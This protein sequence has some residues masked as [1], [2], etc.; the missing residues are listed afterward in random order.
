MKKALSFAMAIGF[1]L[2]AAMVALAAD[3]PP[4]P[5]AAGAAQASAKAGLR[6]GKKDRPDFSLLHADGVGMKRDG[7]M[8]DLRI[9]KG[10]IQAVSDTSIT[11]KSPGNYVQTYKVNAD[12]KVREKK[13]ASSV[14]KLKVGEMAKVTAT[15]D[16]D[17]AEFVARTINCVGEAGPRLQQL[18]DKAA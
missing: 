1:L 15:K 8:V 7:T 2:I 14:D 3:T 9:Q 4:V 6:E 16:K 13:E 17:G 12:T 5:A 10:V 11:L 18:I